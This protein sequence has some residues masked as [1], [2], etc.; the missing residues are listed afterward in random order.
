MTQL[1]EIDPEI[2]AT[3]QIM[4]KVAPGLDITKIEPETARRLSNSVAMVLNDGKPELPRVETIYVDGPAGPIRTR[5][6]QPEHAAGNGAVFYIHGGGWFNCDVDTHDRMLRLLAF[7]SGVSVF[8]VDYRLSPEHVFPAALEDCQAT[9]AWFTSH[10]ATF[11]IS[12]RII[13]SGDSAGANIAMALNLIARDT[14][15]FAPAAAA[16]LYGA[17]APGLQTESRARYGTGPYG[18]TAA[19]MDWYWANYLGPLIGAPPPLAALLDADVHGLPPHYISYA[20]CDVLSSENHLMAEKLRAAGVSVT[21][22]E[23]PTATHGFLQMT[24]D[25]QVARDAVGAAAAWVKGQ[26]GK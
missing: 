12:D 16:Y 8:G 17:Y 2:L 24:R 9:W 23:W 11:G 5:L 7:E 15:T 21:E 25:V 10:A 3:R 1:E 19:R 4:A 22:Q 20:R 26:V 14:G 18:L 13:L 6:Y